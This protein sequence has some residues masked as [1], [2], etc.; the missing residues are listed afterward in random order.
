[1]LENKSS[2]VTNFDRIE[3]ITIEIANFKILQ[4]TIFSTNYQIFLLISTV[5]II[6][7]V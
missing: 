6:S 2:D 3:I 4:I 1:M 7:T 5:L